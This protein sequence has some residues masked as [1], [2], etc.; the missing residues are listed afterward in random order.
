METERVPISLYG[1][2]PHLRKDTRMADHPP[3]K[4]ADAARN[5]QRILEAARAAFAATGA[6]TSMAEIARRS[7]AGSATVY[8][9]FGT[10]R[11]L[12]EALLVDEDDEVCAAAAPAEGD[13]P[14]DRLTAW[15]R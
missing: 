15:L 9:N 11:E 10:R 3:S 2:P 12:L 14:G 6:E 4:R 13:P 5:R 1:D 8:R 7:G